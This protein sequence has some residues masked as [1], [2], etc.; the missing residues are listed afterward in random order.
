MERKG[1]S[2]QSELINEAAQYFNIDVDKADKLAEKAPPLFAAEKVKDQ[3]CEN[4]C[5]VII[6]KG[7]NTCDYAKNYRA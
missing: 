7:E 3:N 6:C 2:E 4:A 5:V 1:C